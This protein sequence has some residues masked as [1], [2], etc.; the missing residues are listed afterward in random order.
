[1][2]DYEEKPKKKKKHHKSK[3]EDKVRAKPVRKY[4]N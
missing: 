1:M 3:D 2:I 4:N